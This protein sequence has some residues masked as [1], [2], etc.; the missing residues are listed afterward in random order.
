VRLATR[1]FLATGG[2][3]LIVIA[4]LVFGLPRAG[5]HLWAVARAA[6]FGLGVAALLTWILTTAIERVLQQ[7]TDVARATAAGIA[8]DFPHTR[9]PELARY[10]LALRVTHDELIARFDALRREREDSRALIESMTDGVVAT[11]VR[12]DIVSSNTAARRLLG[13]KADATL[14]PLAELFH[15]KPARDLLRDIHAGR[16]VEQRELDLEGRTLLVTGRALPD[17][18]TLLVLRDITELRRLETVRR[19]FVANVSH[20]LKTP[21]TSIAGY[22]ETLAAETDSP[23]ARTILSNARRMQRLV[24]ELLDLSRIESGGWRPE[25]RVVELEPLARDAWAPFAER[26]AA[27]HVAFQVTV[28]RD[29]HAVPADPD[30][31][32]QIFT[33]LFDNALRHTPTGGRIRFRADLIQDSVRI[34]IEDNGAGIASEHL[35]RIFERF[36][37]VD[38]GRARDQGG[39]GLGLAIVKHLVEAHGGHVEA[40]S[41]LGRGTAI[42]M[43]LPVNGAA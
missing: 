5:E 43:T 35:P 22:A 8:P 42:R 33:N 25:R 13:Y 23:F 39:T 12:G 37:R 17:G 40:E 36:Y 34:S 16:E 31:L 7:L 20:E 3:V 14:P 30:A 24:D 41:A 4:L 6:V 15:D 29:A 32:R 10:A 26:A 38:T 19:D 21:L 28:A 27:A 18:G 11:N 2:L 1:L 9:I